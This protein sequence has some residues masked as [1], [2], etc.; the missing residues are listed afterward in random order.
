MQAVTSA[1]SVEV[2]LDF[3][4]KLADM[5]VVHSTRVTDGAWV[6]GSSRSFCDSVTHPLNK[7]DSTPQLIWEQIL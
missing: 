6:R 3:S 1:P 2:V 5:E 7:R 4:Q